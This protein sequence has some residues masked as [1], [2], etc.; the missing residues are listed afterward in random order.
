M[1]PGLPQGPLLWLT[2]AAPV[3][4]VLAL[5]VRRQGGGRAGLAG[6]ITAIGLA[7]L[8][9]GAN[10]RVLLVSQ[11]KSLLLSLYVL[12]IIWFA[13]AFYHIVK[14]AGALEAI[15]AG[16]GRHAADR[17]LQLLLLA[18]VFASFL[19]GVT[20]FGVPVAVVAPLLVGLGFPP[21]ASVVAAS[22]GHGWAVTFGSL[23]SSFYAMIAVTRFDGDALAPW[24]ALLL[25]LAC[26]PSGLL[27]AHVFGG[28]RAA[29]HALP[30][31]L[32]IAAAMAGTQYVLAT[33]GLWTLAAFGA[34]LAGL[35]VGGLVTRWPRYRTGAGGGVPAVEAPRMGFGE[36]MAAYA[37]LLAIV[38]VARLVPQ[39]DTALDAVVLAPSFPA[40]V[41]GYGWE[42]APGPAQTISLF[43][44]A[45]ALILYAC[46]AAFLLFR[47]RGRYAPGAA[48]TIARRTWRGASKPTVAILFLVGMAAA[49]SDSG[50]TF[51]LANGVGR[52]TGPLFPLAAPFIGALGAFVT[53]SNTNSNVLFAP[54]QQQTA[55]LLRLDPLLILGGQNVGGAVGSVFAPAKIIVACSTAWAVLTG[56]EGEVLR[57]TLGY[58]LAI[59]TGA[60]ALVLALAVLG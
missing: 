45:G 55:E 54:L 36:A 40:T 25:G 37:I 31:V 15:S 8:L 14:E 22:V 47:A 26:F 42:N 43:G 6:W 58:G 5:M 35:A 32:V 13:V 12:Y 59:I 27:A 33:R 39:V 38:T 30:A 57:L 20:G 4:V 23:A 28:W 17:T 3:L 51:A 18:W 44:H 21:I 41:T 10:A 7:F 56:E 24:S 19:Q 60:G 48:R 1:T 53:G 50:M 46:V 34:G 9:F 16:V 49:M 11:G 29:R 52:L 2:A